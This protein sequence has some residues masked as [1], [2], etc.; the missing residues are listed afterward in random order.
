MKVGFRRTKPELITILL[1]LLLEHRVDAY[2]CGHDH[3]MQFFHHDRVAHFH[4]GM[5]VKFNPSVEN[6][7]NPLIPTGASKF[8]TIFSKEGKKPTKFLHLTPRL[9][10]EFFFGVK[11]FFFVNFDFKN[12]C[13]NEFED[14][15]ENSCSRFKNRVP[16]K[17]DFR[18]VWTHESIPTAWE[19]IKLEYF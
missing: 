2:I 18:A 14:N 11:E 3:N 7:E 1:P 8:W 19:L 13:K 10:G 9:S 5:G 12:G 15:N 16:L 6:Q 17:I 4:S